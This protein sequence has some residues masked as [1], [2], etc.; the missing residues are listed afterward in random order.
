MFSCFLFV[1]FTFGRSHPGSFWKKETQHQTKDAHVASKG[2]CWGTVLGVTGPSSRTCRAQGCVLIVSPKAA[3]RCPLHTASRNRHFENCLL[4]TYTPWYAAVPAGRHF[5]LYKHPL[6][7]NF[8]RLTSES[9]GSICCFIWLQ[10]LLG[11]SISSHCNYRPGSSLF[12]I[13]SPIYKSCT[14]LLKLL[15]L[16]LILSVKSLHLN[17]LTFSIL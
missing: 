2:P 3:P 5:W 13:F 8:S 6:V 4:S 12:S 14:R 1:M 17:K 11:S 9:W 15:W 7:S 16:D 10:I